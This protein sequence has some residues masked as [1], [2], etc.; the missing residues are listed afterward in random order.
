[1]KDLDGS[2]VAYGLGVPLHRIAGLA[3]GSADCMEALGRDSSI[4]GVIAILREIEE[5]ANRAI[6]VIDPALNGEA[7]A[8]PPI[9]LD[10]P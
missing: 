6:G 3:K 4:P 9:S 10:L 7:T 1:M 5:T 8:E 2:A